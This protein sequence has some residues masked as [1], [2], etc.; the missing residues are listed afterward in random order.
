MK[1]GAQ[2]KLLDYSPE[3]TRCSIGEENVRGI[4]LDVD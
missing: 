1:K 2:G 3:P 4:G